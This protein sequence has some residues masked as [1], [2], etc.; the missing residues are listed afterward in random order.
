MR[1]FIKSLK[2][3][4]ENCLGTLEYFVMMIFY[5]NFHNY[6]RKFKNANKKGKIVILA[7]GPSLK[8]VLLKIEFDDE[9]KDSDLCV[10][11]YF[12]NDDLFEILKPQYYVLSDP[13]FLA[14]NCFKERVLVFYETLNRKVNWK[15]NL[16]IPYSFRKQITNYIHNDNINIVYFHSIVYKGFSNIRNYLFKIGLGCADY[17]T[18]VHHCIYIAINL[19]YKE[20]NL[21]GVDHTY[22]D[23]LCVNEKNQVCR[24][25]THYYDEEEPVI[26]PLC[27]NYTGKLVPYNMSFFLY[28][29][30]RIFQGHEIIN[31][32]AKYRS[33]VIYNRTKG[34]MIDAYLRK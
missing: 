22:F 25:V 30:M 26:K 11:N 14:N 32:Y 13:Q 9:C 27:H 28:D 10:V 24:R 4:L 16:C 31:E 21:Y 15:L 20:I 1:I 6:I 29:H 5:E 18:V 3:N 19:G 33:V 8:D 12:A 17:G 34:S 2:K 7:N 23:G